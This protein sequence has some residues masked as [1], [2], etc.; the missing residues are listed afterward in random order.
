MFL[1]TT[2]TGLIC[3]SKLDSEV[4]TLTSGKLLLLNLGAFLVLFALSGVCFFASCLFNRSKYSMSLGGGLSMFA[5]VSTMLG[6]FGSE[7]I[8]SVIR[9]DALNYFNYVSIITMF[10]VV[11][12]V[13]GT[14]A[15]LWKFCILAAVGVVGYVIGSG[16][17]KKKDL[18]L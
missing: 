17:F 13:D 9:L 10:D 8:P 16:I 4:V 1:C 7:I 6:L 18:P 2:V 3:L 11:S 15:F 5:L 14:D 12:I